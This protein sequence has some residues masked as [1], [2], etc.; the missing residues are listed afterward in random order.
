MENEKWVEARINGLSAE[1]YEVSNIG[2]VRNKN[3]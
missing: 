1:L 3:S 2:N